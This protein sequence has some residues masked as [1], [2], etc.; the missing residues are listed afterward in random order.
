MNDPKSNQ[1]PLPTPYADD[2]RVARALALLD[3]VVRE[4]QAQFTEV[5]PPK[6]ELAATYRARLEEFA[7]LRSGALY[8]PYL[9]TGRGD[10]AWVELADG[11]V[12]LDFISGIGVHG[13]G[14]AHP[15][16]R[17]CGVQ[18]ALCDTVMQGNLQQLDLSIDVCR[19]FVEIGSQD[20]AALE[21]VTLTTSGAMA[22][23]NALKLAFHARPG[24]TRILAFDRCFAGRTMLLSQLTDKAA[25]R[26][27]L[28]TSFPIDYL[29]F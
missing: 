7:K 14:H 4:G 22:N 21:H 16:M 26:V 15:V 17:R 24:R 8:Y 23:E 28:P 20:G 3:E 18:A 19:R 5:R 25:Y 9:A 27:G 11:S 29:P 6:P 10:G 13:F 2:P 1:T 12:K